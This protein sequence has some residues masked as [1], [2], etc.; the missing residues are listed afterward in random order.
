M[1][2]SGVQMVVMVSGWCFVLVLALALALV[3]VLALVLL[4]GDAAADGCVLVV[5]GARDLTG[6]IGGPALDRPLTRRCE[7]TWAL[8]RAIV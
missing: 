7:I 3:L 4:G 2:E 6:G 5:V 8:H 1:G